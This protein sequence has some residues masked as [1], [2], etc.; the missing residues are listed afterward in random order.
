MLEAELWEG[1][2]KA[3][4]RI[5]E[6]LKDPDQDVRSAAVSVLSSLGAYRMCPGSV[7]PLPG[8]INDV[9]SPIAQFNTECYIRSDFLGR[10]SSFKPS[11]QNP[12]L[13]CR[14]VIAS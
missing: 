14:A 2:G 10:L 7:S 12:C 6:C 1:I 8:V 4:P 3:I 11:G 9:V 13:P 5:V